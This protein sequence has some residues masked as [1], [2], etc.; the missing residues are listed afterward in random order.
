MR[1]GMVLRVGRSALAPVGA[2]A[3]AGPSGVGRAAASPAACRSALAALLR[4]SSRPSF[5][6]RAGP[7]SVDEA[8]GER[9]ATDGA[10]REGPRGSGRP[11]R[12]DAF[13]PRS[14]SGGDRGGWR[15]R[16]EGGGGRF[17]R[18]SP[19]EDAYD[20]DP[21]RFEGQYDPREF[22]RAMRLSEAARGSSSEGASAAGLDD[23]EVKERWRPS[24]RGSADRRADWER[25]WDDDMTDVGGEWGDRRRGG[26]RG[27]EVR[28]GGRRGGEFSAPADRHDP[29]RG[30]A[31]DVRAVGSGSDRDAFARSDDDFD[32]SLFEVGAW[33]EAPRRVT[34]AV[35]D[36]GRRAASDRG[37]GDAEERGWRG[38]EGRRPERAAPSPPL[39]PSVLSPPHL[40]RRLPRGFVVAV[41]K[42]LGWTSFQVVAAVRGR[43][44]R[45]VGARTKLIKVGHAGTLDPLATGVLVLGI[46]DGTKALHDLSG[47]DKVYAGT[48]A[49]GAQTPTLD[50]ETEPEARAPWAHVSAEAVQA[51]ASPGGLVGTLHLPPPMFSAVKQNGKRL[52]DLAR[53]GEDV[54]RETRETLVHSLDLGSVSPQWD[55][56]WRGDEEEREDEGEKRAEEEAD[57]PE[58]GENEGKREGAERG[59]LE[60]SG[61]GPSSTP[62]APANCEGNPP[63]LS[64]S[65]SSSSSSA[66]PFV[67]E[68]APPPAPLPSPLPRLA[69]GLLTSPQLS[70][71]MHVGKGT[72]VRSVA[73]ELGKRLGTLAHV[74][75]LRR[76]RSGAL[77]IDDAWSLERLLEELEQ[78]HT[79]QQWKK[80]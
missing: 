67:S 13:G 33:K 77:G 29:V 35:S 16:R 58:H 56:G 50:A 54:E 74:R 20:I 75:T 49:L 47:A 78:T 24:R 64:P 76:E 55:D 18:R 3:A 43:L 25:E 23:E 30:R 66:G 51:A 4:G 7:D 52:Y 28:G 53:K 71:R 61:R 19:R 17:E 57:G 69:P 11:G 37:R 45:A 32:M 79:F 40:P 36:W 1:L 34:A 46:G 68:F 31:G 9:G 15:G 6:S 2:A 65:S 10:W 62:S 73:Q 26:K 80:E 21:P 44:A 70:Y 63:A 12:R 59:D 48:L 22:E 41:D 60:E 14:R 38:R 72:Y 27:E 8:A 39:P 5:A 42:P